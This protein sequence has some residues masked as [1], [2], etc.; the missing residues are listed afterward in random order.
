MKHVVSFFTPVVFFSAVYSVSKCTRGVDP[1]YLWELC[2]HSVPDRPCTATAC[3]DWMH[4]ATTRTQYVKRTAEFRFQWNSSPP[5]V[6]CTTTVSHWT[7]SDRNWKRS[8]TGNDWHQPAPLWRVWNFGAA[9][10]ASVDIYL[11]TGVYLPAA[12]PRHNELYSTWS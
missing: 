6:P 4:P 2:I 9:I 3:E 7:F 5:A 8:S 10:Y 1:A 11:H 12:E